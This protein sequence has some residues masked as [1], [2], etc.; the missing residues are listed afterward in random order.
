MSMLV[1]LALAF[2]LG[3]FAGVFIA[4]LCRMGRSD[5]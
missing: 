4:A 2:W 1:Y 5:A 3:V